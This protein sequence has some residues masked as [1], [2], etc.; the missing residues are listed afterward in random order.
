MDEKMDVI[1]GLGDLLTYL[2]GWQSQHGVKAILVIE[3]PPLTVQHVGVTRAEA[4]PLLR[5]A[6]A[7]AEGIAHAGSSPTGNE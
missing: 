2:H 7:M 5:E 6:A 4:V 3:G 1:P